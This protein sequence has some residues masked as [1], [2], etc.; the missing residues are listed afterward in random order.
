MLVGNLSEPNVA[1][2]LGVSLVRAF[3]GAWTF[4]WT[5]ARRHLRRQAPGAPRTE[6]AQKELSL[7]GA[8]VE[9]AQIPDYERAEHLLKRVNRRFQ[10]LL[11][12]MDPQRDRE[13]TTTIAFRK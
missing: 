3:A 12:E 8:G 4:C 11:E 2:L 10:C 6:P 9:R 13:Q 7:R 5:S 1:P